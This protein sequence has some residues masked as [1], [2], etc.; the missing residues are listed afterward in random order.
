MI[1]LSQV[2]MSLGYCIVLVPYLFKVWCSICL[3]SAV[4]ERGR[5]LSLVTVVAGDFVFFILVSVVR[6]MVKVMFS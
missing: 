1:R 3:S 4:V 2:D 6:Y 5:L